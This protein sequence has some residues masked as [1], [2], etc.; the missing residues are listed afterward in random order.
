MYIVDE[1]GSYKT[2]ASSCNAVVQI[3]SPV[4]F[5]N[6]DEI[7]LDLLDINTDRAV[8]AGDKDRVEISI[9]NKG[10]GIFYIKRKW[11]NTSS[12]ARRIQTIFRISP[13]F[14]VEHFI[15]PSVNI[16]GNEFGAGAEPKGLEKN[17]KKWIFGYDREPIPSCTHTENSS[18]AVSLFASAKTVES[19]VSSCSIWK[20]DQS[21]RFYQEIYHPKTEAPEVYCTR[22]AYSA[23]T[24]E[25]LE[26]APE[27]CFEVG[28]YIVVAEPKWERYGICKTLDTAISLFDDGRELT[29]HNGKNIWD[30]SIKFAR[31]LITDYKG[32]KGFIIG[33]RL[34]DEG[35][36]AHSTSDNFF[37]LAWCGQNVLLS[38]MLIEDYIINGDASSLNEALE[39][40]D[41]RVK[42]CV[43]DNGLLA[44]QLKHSDN[45]QEGI[46]DTCNM[47]YGAY[48]L[49]R[50]HQ[51]LKKINID[52]PE[53]LRA[54]LALCDF[55]VDNYSEEFGF[56]KSWRHDGVCV[57]KGGTIGG[58]VIPAL[59]KAYEITN[60][61]EYLELAEKAMLFYME[62]DINRFCCTAGALDTCCVDKE[63]A[64]PFI[65]SAVLLYKLTHKE[66]YLE[67]GEKAA[68]YFSAWMY[69]YQPIYDKDSDITR[70]G[71]S[72]R[73][74]TA[75]SA[76]HHHL[77]MYAA[78]IVPYLKRLAEFTGNDIWKYR[79]ELMWSA[80]LQCIGDGELE[81]H[82]LVRPEGSQN[83]GIFHCSWGFRQYKRGNLNDWLVAWPCAFRLSVL[84]GELDP[85]N[86]DI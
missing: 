53:Y 21:G 15:I 72:I 61:P 84:A 31:S 9:E 76:Q 19:L 49:M 65:M 43:S 58:F 22:D 37:E 33:F 27:E 64:A 42:Y 17:G 75:V 62:R 24:E 48:E 73:G 23:A 55:F 8:Y 67:Y 83:E 3:E 81:I 5:E 13:C 52:K 14:D 36:F 69:C 68:Y 40:L 29:A 71:V 30:A 11:Y 80:V 4:V 6:K 54:G 47:G 41:T 63:T 10:E 39:I 70:Y 45:M 12:V 25:Y 28:M 16:D 85:D 86:F 77:D 56:G 26:L 35:V 78:I 74:L 2:S 60:K 1:K 57:D 7:T 66:I 59:A 18:V 50:T 82:G 51:L 32:K 46:S 38:R 79:A 20:D 44:S 34:N